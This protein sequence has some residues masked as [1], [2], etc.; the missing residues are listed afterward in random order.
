MASKNHG[1]IFN[2]PVSSNRKKDSAA[3]RATKPKHGAAGPQQVPIIPVKDPPDPIPKTLRAVEATPS[4]SSAGP[5]RT[6]NRAR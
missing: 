2:P 5:H 1:E 3:P 4:A 6:R